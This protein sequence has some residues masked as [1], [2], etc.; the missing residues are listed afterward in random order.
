MYYINFDIV[1]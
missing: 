1:S